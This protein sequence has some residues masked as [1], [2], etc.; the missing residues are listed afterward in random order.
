MR[1]NMADIKIPEWLEKYLDKNGNEVGP[2]TFGENV[3]IVGL[4][5]QFVGVA[6]DMNGDGLVVS[7]KY[8]G[9]IYRFQDGE[10]TTF[11]INEAEFLVAVQRDARWEELAEN[12]PALQPYWLGVVLKTK[13][14][15]G[16]TLTLGFRGELHYSAMVIRAQVKAGEMLIDALDRELLEVMEIEDYTVTDLFDDGGVVDIKNIEEPLF[17][18][19]VEVPYFDVEKLIQDKTAEWVEMEKK[20]IVN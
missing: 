11:A 12:M 5:G 15:D 4:S 3:E 7:K 20:R 18:V 10:L 8:D 14:D 19:T 6:E 13:T 17:T 2:Y 16:R 9:V 1:N